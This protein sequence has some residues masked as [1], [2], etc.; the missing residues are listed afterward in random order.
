MLMTLNVTTLTLARK[1]L[2][3]KKWRITAEGR[4]AIGMCLLCLIEK[5]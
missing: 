2:Y 3:I 4:Y 1:L 5:P